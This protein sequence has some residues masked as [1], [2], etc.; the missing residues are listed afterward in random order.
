[1]IYSLDILY[2]IKD[3]DLFDKN[4]YT[5][6]QQFLVFKNDIQYSIFAH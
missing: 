4:F 5:K 6:L 1:M 3:H 2:T